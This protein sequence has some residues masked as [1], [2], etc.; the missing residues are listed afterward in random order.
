MTALNSLKRTLML[1]CLNVTSHSQLTIANL[2][3]SCLPPIDDGSFK[4]QMSS[5]MQLTGCFRCHDGY[6]WFKRRTLAFS[7]LNVTSHSQLTIA[8]LRARFLPLIDD[9][10]FKYL[11]RC[12]WQTVS[13]AMTALNGS[14][15][16]PWHCLALMWRPILS[17]QFPTGV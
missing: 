11:R 12:S 17:W 2:R 1:S 16:V 13:S 14:Q 10:S 9:G 15:D 8:N 5:K 3:A 7:C 6:E 4:I